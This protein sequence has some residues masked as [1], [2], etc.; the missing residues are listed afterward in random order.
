MGGC[1]DNFLL[2]KS[3]IIFMVLDGYVILVHNAQEA[4]C[5]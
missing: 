3:F 1:D 5:L 2:C 4:N